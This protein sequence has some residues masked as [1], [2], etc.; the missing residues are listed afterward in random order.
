MADGTISADK[1][2]VFQSGVVSF[3]VTRMLASK[4]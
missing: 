4:E 3:L 1:M 2:K